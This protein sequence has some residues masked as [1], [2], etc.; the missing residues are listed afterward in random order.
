MF[1]ESLL[2]WLRPISR[3][4][5]APLPRTTRLQVEP[6]EHRLTP[7][8]DY[9]LLADFEGDQVQRY[10]GSTGAFVDTFVP[11]H[12]GGMYQPWGVLFGPD[13]NGDGRND[14]YVSTGEFTG[15]GQLKAVLRYDGTSGAF[16]DVFTKGAD[17]HSLRGIIFGP[18]GN[19]YVAD[20]DHSFG[21]RVVR[22]NGQTGEFIDDF[23]PGG[24]GGLSGI[25]GL[26]FGP[27]GRSG[28]TLDLYVTSGRGNSILR[29]DGVTG[30]FVDVFA[31]PG[32]GGLASPT[33]LTFGP[34]GNLYVTS[35]PEANLSVLRFQ[36]PSGPAPG[37]FI[38]TFVPAGSGGLQVPLGVIFGPDGNRDGALDL[39]VSDGRFDGGSLTG[40][41]GT[42]KRYDGVTGAFI[43]VFVPERSGGL[44]R[45]SMITFTATDPVTLAYMDGER[46]TAASLPALSTNERLDA[47]HAASLLAEAVARWQSAGVDPSSHHGID[48]RVADLGGLTLGMASGHTIWLDDNAAGWGWFVDRTPRNDSEFYRPGNQG[49][50][51]RIDLL[52]VIAHE[53]GHLLGY[54]HEHDGVMIDTL[55]TGTRRVPS[56]GITTATSLDGRDLFFAFLDAD[57]ESAYAGSSIFGRGRKRR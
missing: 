27:S 47:K 19:L 7:S 13:G 54:E 55:G 35:N 45:P 20:F 32:S 30:A 29:Y 16:I 23:V 3:P 4:A 2:G 56:D 21:G 50:K 14:L 31:A 10:D 36:G 8:G 42:V 6:L 52:T 57:G 28:R 1:L 22:F 25:R 53:V 37:A 9:L 41:K 5:A 18:D 24:S 44:R 34:D 46:L 49:E 26:V 15:N 12:V 51:N 48:I 43:D 33:G 38:D 11:K 39:Y 17:L 40:K